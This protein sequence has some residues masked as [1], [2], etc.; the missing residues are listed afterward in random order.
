MRT[1]SDSSWLFRVLPIANW[2][3][4]LAASTVRA[5]LIAGIAL[6][7]LLVPEG[8]AYAGIAGMPPQ[9]VVFGGRGA[10]AA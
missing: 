10:R 4:D 6:A 1:E 9:T 2:L 7:G 8:L 3:P 5:D